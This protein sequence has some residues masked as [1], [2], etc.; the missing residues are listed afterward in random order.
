M[1][2]LGL[3]DGPEGL[4]EFNH[5]LFPKQMLLFSLVRNVVLLD[6]SMPHPLVEFL[7]AGETLSLGPE[8]NYLVDV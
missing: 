3:V 1:N 5:L 7:S 8:R 4:V 6:Q 2:E